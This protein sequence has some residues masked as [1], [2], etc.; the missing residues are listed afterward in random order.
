MIYLRAVKFEH[1]LDHAGVPKWRQ[2]S[3]F[4]ATMPVK[5]VW[6]LATPVR[7]RTVGRADSRFFKSIQAQCDDASKMS[8]LLVMLTGLYH[9]LGHEDYQAVVKGTAGLNVKSA[10]TFKYRGKNEKVWE[11]KYQNKDRLYFFSYSS[12]ASEPRNLL[13][14]LIFL[15]KKDQTT[16]DTIKDQCEREMKPLLDPRPQITLLKE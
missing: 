6:T 5:A 11:L 7:D 9:A 16:P 2:L 3:P 12:A 13:I 15:H 4:L 10:H 8:S 14:P 1:I